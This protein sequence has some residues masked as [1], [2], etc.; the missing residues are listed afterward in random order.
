MLVNSP[1][2]GRAV[3][4]ALAFCPAKSRFPVVFLCWD[5]KVSAL[6]SD[7]Y[8][9]GEATCDP[10]QPDDFPWMITLRRADAI[11]LEKVARM[12]VKGTGSLIYT[13]GKGGGPA[14]IEFQPA[15]KGERILAQDSSEPRFTRLWEKCLSSLHDWEDRDNMPMPYR[16]AF[17]P[18]LLMRFSKIK[19]PDGVP[20][21]MDCD[22]ADDSLPILVKIGPEFRGA[23]MPVTRSSAPE[24]ALWT[25]SRSGGMRN[26]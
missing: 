25:R 9:I 11:A 20:L 5:G 17:S 7:T 12:D 26:R 22:V 21:I 3:H 13:R 24:G 19:V 4:N 8:T 23:I 2:L 18:D 15:T 6:S 16:L 1:A 10:E 14:H